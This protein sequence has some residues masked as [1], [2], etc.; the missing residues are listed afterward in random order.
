MRKMNLTKDEATGMCSARLEL[1]SLLYQNLEYIDIDSIGNAI[2]FASTGNETELLK[3][4][5]HEDH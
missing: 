3:L 5:R 1:T 4:L 2:Y